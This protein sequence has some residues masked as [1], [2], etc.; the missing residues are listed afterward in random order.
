MPP[1][2]TLYALLDAARHALEIKDGATARRLTALVL[3]QQPDHLEA[4]HLSAFAVY[5]LAF[6][7]RSVPNFDNTLLT[8][9]GE[10]GNWHLTLAITLDKSGQAELARLAYRTAALLDFHLLPALRIGFGGPFNGQVM[11]MATF[12][13]LAR[14]GRLGE[15]VE[16][17]AHRG[18]TTE[19]M[20]QRVACPV[21][22]TE[23]DP[24]YFE[25]SRLRFEELKGLGCSWV[26]DLQLHELDSRSFLVEVLKQPVPED[27]LSF[28][29][30]DA[31]CDYLGHRDVENPLVGEVGLIRP[32]RRHCIILIDDCEVP[33]DPGYGFEPG[34]SP[35]ALAPLL[36]S[37]DSWFFPQGVRHET[38]NQRGSIVLS[39]SPETTALLGSIPELRPG[40]PD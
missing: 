19:F 15:V 34:V 40:K 2:S 39:G 10:T 14:S 35:E 4:R 20:A 33:D 28:F 24:Y 5:F 22:T 11:R 30:L 36:P 23:K 16:T 1:P 7:D 37:F 38:G 32:A 31:H 6:G 13:A 29:Y 27:G 26:N 21:K 18:T 12:G 9:R 17:G 3:A 25:A 8:L